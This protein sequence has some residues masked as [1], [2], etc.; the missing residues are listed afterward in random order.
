MTRRVFVW[1]HRWT[2]LLTSGFLVVT[3]LTGS[4]LAFN[5][6]LERLISPHLYAMPR[7]GVAPLDLGT[8]AERVERLV[9]QARVGGVQF[10]ET[11][12]ASVEFI[13]RKDPATGQ[14]YNLGFTQFFLDPWTGE[15]LGRRIRGDL[16]QGWI[17]LMPF[18]Y[19]VHW[20]LA[21]GTPG[22]WVLG[23]IAVIWSIDCF[24][25]FYL[26]L[27]VAIA[28]FWRRWKPS[29]LIKRR[30][31]FFR[32]NFDLHRAGGLWLW[33]MLFIFAWS[34]VM[35]DMR[36]VYEWAMRAAFDYHS[37][38]DAYRSL[39]RRPS[40][41]PRLGWRAALATGER[42]MAAEALSRGFTV[43]QPLGLAYSPDF[44]AYFY[45]VRG[46]RDIFERAPKGGSTEVMFDG[47]TGALVKLFLPTGEHAGNTVEAWLY[48]LHMTRVFGRAYQ[49]FVCVL[50]LLI[51]LLSVTGAYV[52]WRKR[53]AREFSA[54]HAHEGGRKQMRPQVWRRAD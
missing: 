45:E 34:S 8:L 29:W 47:E 49:I 21:L 44:G 15:E 1:L 43:G 4:L 32:L 24:V 17:N 11:D 2:G 9:P 25:G 39:P 10:T 52:W 18:I 14:P 54:S 38:R 27:P 46:S 22:F 13:A 31:G 12:Q 53:R 33:P 36:P 35:M 30:A 40:E 7:P 50:G 51:T 42:L 20:E 26:T 41:S 28:T 23:I 3:A 19:D 48:A 16:S 5:S 37:P 6:E